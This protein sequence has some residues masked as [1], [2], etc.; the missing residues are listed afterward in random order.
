M[1][2]FG[3]YQFI[4]YNASVTYW[5]VARPLMR[6]GVYKHLL[7]SLETLNKAL[8]ELNDEDYAWRAQIAV[9]VPFEHMGTGHGLLFL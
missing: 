3:R 4:T 9:Y 5:Q 2:G 1:G 6:P 7:P 8:E